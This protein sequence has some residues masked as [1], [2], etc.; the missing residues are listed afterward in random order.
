MFRQLSLEFDP[1]RAESDTCPLSQN[2][3]LLFPKL[4]EIRFGVRPETQTVPERICHA[5]RLAR[6]LELWAA[7]LEKFQADL[8]KRYAESRQKRYLDHAA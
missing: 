7:G 4:F 5:R 2:A 1:P 6:E 3:V 8:K